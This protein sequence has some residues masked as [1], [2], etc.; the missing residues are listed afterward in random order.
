MG[1]GTGSGKGKTCGRGHKGA[2]ARAGRTGRLGFEGGTN[3]A[4]ARIP[5]R[6]FN[7]ANFR[8]TYQVVNLSDLDAF[9]DGARVDAA[10]LVEAR[11][12]R[13]ASKPVKILGNG[14]LTK[15]LTVAATKFSASAAQK[16]A[17]AGGATEENP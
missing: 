3:P 8:T 2:G 12:I 11:L 6:G 15:K 7:N 14:D 1:R 16:I 10:A 17:A 5:K 13:D 9:E 4:L